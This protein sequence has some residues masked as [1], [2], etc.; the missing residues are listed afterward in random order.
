MSISPYTAICAL[1][2]LHS[3]LKTVSSGIST[4]WPM[5]ARFIVSGGITAGRSPSVRGNI[6]DVPCGK[7]HGMVIEV[8]GIED[9]LIMCELDEKVK[10]FSRVAGWIHNQVSNHGLKM[11]LYPLSPQ[12]ACDWTDNELIQ[13]V[14]DP[15]GWLH[16]VHTP[17][18]LKVLAKKPAKLHDTMPQLKGKSTPRQTNIRHQLK[19]DKR[20]K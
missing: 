7:M 5:K 10:K 13:S 1:R 9:Q 20:L 4:Y 3:M 15:V 14:V 18:F 12:K 2:T 8:E 16:V 19:T 6:I 17:D 11:K